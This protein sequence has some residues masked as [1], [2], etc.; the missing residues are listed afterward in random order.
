MTKKLDMEHLDEIQTLRDEFVKNTNIL[1]NIAIERHVTEMRLKTIDSE[2]QRYLDQ[3]EN[4]QKQESTLLEKMRERYGEGQIN[5]AEG[6]F[7]PEP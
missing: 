2:E 3:F 4:L 6:T 5:I 7:T 1:G